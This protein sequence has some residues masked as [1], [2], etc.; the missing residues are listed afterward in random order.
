MSIGEDEAQC[1]IPHRLHSL[2]SHITLT[3]LNLGFA[4]RM[5]LHLCRR[6][7]TRRNSKLKAKLLPS[8]NAMSKRRLFLCSDISTGSAIDQI[9]YKNARQAAKAQGHR[10][11]STRIGCFS[12]A[13]RRGSILVPPAGIE[14]TSQPSE[15][16][17]LSIELRRRERLLYR[18]PPPYLFMFQT[19]QTTLHIDGV[20]LNRKSHS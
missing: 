15:G 8:S 2:N 7:K 9:P 3:D 5:P 16:H 14:P 20:H 10:Q 18:S 4:R 1:I 13:S 12:K 19:N 17:I 6:R 11:K